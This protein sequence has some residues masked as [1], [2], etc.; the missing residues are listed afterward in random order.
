MKLLANSASIILNLDFYAEI[1]LTPVDRI[2][3][4]SLALNQGVFH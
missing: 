4:E 3:D 2:V 1:I